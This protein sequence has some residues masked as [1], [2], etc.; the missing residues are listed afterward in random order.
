M[1]FSDKSILLTGASSGIGYEMA[2][3]LAGENCR[4]ALL[5]RSI[6][7]LNETARQLS[8]PSNTI[9][10]LQ[11]DVS[12][13]EEVHSAVDKVMEEFGGIDILILNAGTSSRIDAEKFSAERGEEMMT[14]NLISKFYFLE[15]LIPHFISKRSGMIAGVSSLADVRGF[16]RSGFYNAGKAGF[17]RLL[18][19]LRIELKDY[20]IK[21]ITIRPGFVK[22]PMTDKNEFHMPFLMDPGKAARI[23]IDGIKKEKRTI[24]FP[25]PTVLGTRLL[26]ILPNTLF[27]YLAAKHLAGLKK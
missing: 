1:N 7:K 4:L 25:L 8:T 10:P 26:N 21:V 24:Q 23:I 9:L 18:E 13:K 14:V 16:P 27:E 22:T 6:N 19:S 5:A 11:C 2:V 12:R 17:S 3:L 15:K 20:N